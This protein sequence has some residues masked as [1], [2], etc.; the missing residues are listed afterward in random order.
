M[1]IDQRF[2]SLVEMVRQH[3]GLS[4]KAIFDALAD[5]SSYPTTKRALVTLLERGW[6]RT[7]GSGKATRYFVSPTFALFQEV[8]LEA[9]FGREIDERLVYEQ[10]N[11]DLIYELLAKHVLFTTTEVAALDAL[12]QTFTQNVSKLSPTA[13]RQE[14]ERLAIDLSW[15]SSQ[16]EGNTYSLLETERLLRD[17][18]TAAG[19]TRE[20]AIMLLNHKESIDFLVTHPDYLHPLRVSTIEDVHSLLVKDLAIDRNLRNSRVGISGTNYR[21][22]DNAHQ[23]KEA[24]D[25]MCVLIN[26]KSYVFEKALLALLL[27]SYI[28]PFVDGNKRTARIVCNA[29]LM[30]AGVCPLS[31]R[32][33]DSLHYKK[34]MLLFYEQNNVSAFKQLFIDQFAFAVRTYF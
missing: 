33:A 6:L 25:A 19:K 18:E 34:A 24:L 1:P 27:I 17:K 4:S 31:F 32:T 11:F 15:K 22:L 2:K 10:F 30:H 3:P 23:I 29:L 7:E 14:L 16:M 12:Q 28:Q 21:P 26:S 8:D 9:Y 5:G 13:Y 20:E